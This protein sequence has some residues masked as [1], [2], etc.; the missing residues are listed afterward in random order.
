VKLVQRIHLKESETERAHAALTEGV[1]EL[2]HALH[3]KLSSRTAMVIGFAGGWLLGWR[4]PRRVVAGSASRQRTRHLP[5]HWLRQYF[6]W[7][8]LLNAAREY[9]LVRR[10]SRREA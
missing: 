8:F 7:P 4:G 5:P 2:K 10:P 9:L 1:Y 6:V 3:D